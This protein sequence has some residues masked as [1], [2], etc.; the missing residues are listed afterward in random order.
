M[1]PT[2]SR[3]GND[4]LYRAPTNELMV[5]AFSTAEGVFR[6]EPPQAWSPVRIPARPG[7]RAFDLHPD[8]ERVAIAERATDG[9]ASRDHVTLVTDAFGRLRRLA[10]SA[11]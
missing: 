3:R 10:P 7:Q 4:L 2:W 8:G 9:A 5:V 6:P 1:T 11:P